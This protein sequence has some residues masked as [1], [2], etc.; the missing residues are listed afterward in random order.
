VN[1]FGRRLEV[2]RAGG[3]WMSLTLPRSRR[4]IGASIVTAVLNLGSVVLVLDLVQSTKPEASFS[5]SRLIV[6]LV[7]TLDAFEVLEGVQVLLK[8][9]SIALFFAH[10]F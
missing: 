9:A 7:I 4:E 6:Y 10:Q 5:G 1:E 3:A 2:E 8:Q